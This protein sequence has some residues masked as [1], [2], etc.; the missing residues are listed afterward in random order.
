MIARKQ[1]ARKMRN[2]LVMGLAVAVG[3]GLLACSGSDGSSDK[4][5]K[6]SESSKSPEKVDYE[7]IAADAL[8]TTE[9][10]TLSDHEPEE[11]EP[12]TWWAGEA[13]FYE[14]PYDEPESFQLEASAQQVFQGD[15]EVVAT[16]YAVEGS[17]AKVFADLRE[18][19]DSKNCRTFYEIV[20]DSD[21]SF[22]R[23]QQIKAPK[24]IDA[25]TWF[26]AC[27]AGYDD[28]DK[29]EAGD[30]RLIFLADARTFIELES[31]QPPDENEINAAFLTLVAAE[32]M[33]G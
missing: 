13:P 10:E 6:P 2:F 9:L 26:G 20:D 33:S 4:K 5:A 23:T 19:W 8:M 11:D 7:K 21:M 29:Y 22:K 32:A 3:L 18:I 1:K 17:A 30:C 14:C 16:A 15:P 27:H 28:A 24:S 12:W 25:D 31:F